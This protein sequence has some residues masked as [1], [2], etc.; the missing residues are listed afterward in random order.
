M[1][2]ARPGHRGLLGL[3]DL[4]DRKDC[5]DLLARPVPTVCRGLP[6]LPLI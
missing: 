5:R 2:A 3:L 6:A 4:L 1:A